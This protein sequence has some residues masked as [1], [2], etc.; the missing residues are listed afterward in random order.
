MLEP[1]DDV[2]PWLPNRPSRSPCPLLTSV[3]LGVALAPSVVNFLAPR[4]ILTK[5][6]VGLASLRVSISARC[7]L[8]ETLSVGFLAYPAP[9]ASMDETDEPLAARMRSASKSSSCSSVVIEPPL[10]ARPSGPSACGGCAAGRL[11]HHF[12]TSQFTQL[13][14]TSTLVK[15]L[16][17]AFS[18]ALS[19]PG[20]S[21]T[22]MN[23][24]VMGLI[25]T[26]CSGTST[27]LTLKRRRYG[28]PLRRVQKRPS[29][30]FPAM[31][32]SLTYTRSGTGTANLLPPTLALSVM[33]IALVSHTTSHS[34]MVSPSFPRQHRDEL[35]F[36]GASPSLNVVIS[37]DSKYAGFTL[38]NTLVKMRVKSLFSQN[39]IQPSQ[40]D[41]RTSDHQSAVSLPSL[42]SLAYPR[43][44]WNR[45]SSSDLIRRSRSRRCRASTRATCRQHH[46]EKHKIATNCSWKRCSKNNGA[47][48]ANSACGPNR[49]PNQP[50]TART[51]A[52]AECIVR[53]YDFFSARA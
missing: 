34:K 12:S 37:S 2:P 16:L 32:K 38:A 36:G 44:P 46:H 42:C 48:V 30:N 33:F 19:T 10:R 51:G 27:K 17:S 3:S 43:L 9:A 18:I 47:T 41:R 21:L 14:S 50:F 31:R 22:S 11:I 53:R 45:A 20:R 23:E 28:P 35:T 26:E 15:S 4:L 13:G 5:Y 8:T 39:S 6:D 7:T 25:T 49:V 24:L 1:L 52:Y 40:N 29:R